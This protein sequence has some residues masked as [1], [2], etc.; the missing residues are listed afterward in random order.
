VFASYAGRRAAADSKMHR[1][2]PLSITPRRQSEA[3]GSSASAPQDSDTSAREYANILAK[4]LVYSRTH[5]CLCSSMIGAATIEIAW[6][7][8]PQAGGVGH[9]PDHPL[10][11]V[12]EAYVT[13]GLVCE[14]LLRFALSKREELCRNPAHMLE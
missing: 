14:I 13:V 11:M 12:I 4:R 7:I 10:F 3:V 6:I 1:P 5:T 8:A 9:L 2:L